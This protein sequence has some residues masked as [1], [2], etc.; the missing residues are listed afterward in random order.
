MTS[1]TSGQ[2]ADAAVATV[3]RLEIK[4]LTVGARLVQVMLV[5]EHGQIADS[6]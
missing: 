2:A 6:C 1:R 5:A 3:A 4:V